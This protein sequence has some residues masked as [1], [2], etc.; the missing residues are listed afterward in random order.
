[1]KCPK[2]G[3]TNK[4]PADGIPF[5]VYELR[6]I[7]KSQTPIFSELGKGGQWSLDPMLVGFVNTG[8]A[9]FIEGKGF[10][11]TER[12]RDL[13]TEYRIQEEIERTK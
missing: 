2:C 13:V 11:V 3:Y 1:M 10:V 9:L 12:G 6:T 7:A 4:P 5:W 8:L